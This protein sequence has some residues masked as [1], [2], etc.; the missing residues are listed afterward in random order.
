[1]KA[2]RTVITAL[3]ALA[4]AASAA[5]DPPER[6]ARIS[7]LSGVVS[8]RS[9]DATDW[10]ATSL[11]Y[12]VTIGD[13]LWTDRTGRLELQLGGTAIDADAFTA[14]SVLNLDAHVAQLRVAEGSVIA[15][16]R[17]LPDDET[18]EIDTPNG[19]ITL[20]RPGLYR[21]DVPASGD[22][23]TLTVRRGDAEVAAGATAFPV[24]AEQ[25]TTVVG[26]DAAS[27]TFGPPVRLDEFEDWVT[28]RERRAES[29]VTARYVPPGLVGYEDLDE[30]GSWR[31]VADYGP[32]WVPH[33]RAEW[34]PYRYGHWAWVP[35]WG[36][37]W[38]DD[39]P[40]GFAPFHYGRWAYV[41]DG[42]VWVPGTI[43]AR[44]VYSPALVAF[45]GGSG[46]R[47]GVSVNEPIGWF[48]LG[49]R[50]AFVPA[51]AVS[52]AYV[53]AVNRP[54]VA[55][56][57]VN[58]NVTTVSYV[59]RSVAGAVTVVSRET[60]AQA[61]PVAQAA[62][63]V[64][65]ASL[66]AAVV[67]GH[68]A[69]REVVAAAVVRTP[70]T[71]APPPA[72]VNRAV[73]VRSTPAAAAPQPV[74]R[75]A[76]PSPPA[77]PAQPA[78]AAAAVPAPVSAPPAPVVRQAAPDREAAAIA[79]RQAQERV[80]QEAR[81]AAER[82]QLQARQQAEAQRAATAQAQAQVQARHARERADLDQ[83]QKREHDEIQK[84]QEAE[85]RRKQ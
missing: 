75:A 53:V 71:A 36:W 84:R 6:V 40:W 81:H 65:P 24:H 48:P 49:P 79:T 45:V 72:V 22:A 39:A 19:A 4:I 73:I 38:V 5:A 69:P 25:S 10:T 33:V 68:A 16:I 3:G 80:D 47:I 78:A 57:N 20:L 27:H 31:V 23:T 32:V 7:F 34:V 35:P 76:V 1:M 51:Y 62:V 15:R 85:R 18:L 37:T 74:R 67:V 63:A 29:L 12:P 28:F 55:V 54:H 58:V 61:R 8:F 17:A 59:N 60:F 14:V 9:A 46:W 43:V 52:P 77:R 56:T 50:E 83:R 64:P 70:V 42:W 44:P 13:H 66:R 82:A 26:V 2:L 21:V 30:Y 11:N 41:G